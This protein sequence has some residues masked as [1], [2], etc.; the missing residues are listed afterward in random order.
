MKTIVSCLVLVFVLSVVPALSQSMIGAGGSQGAGCSIPSP[1][2]LHKCCS[3]A[4]ES[5]FD[6][7]YADCMNKV[8]ASE[9]GCTGSAVGA[10]SET[11]NLCY[12]GWVPLVRALGIEVPFNVELVQNGGAFP[13]LTFRASKPNDAVLR[14]FRGSFTAGTVSVNGI[15]VADFASPAFRE[16]GFIF[17][18]AHL[19]T[20]TNTITV[21]AQ[22]D[23]RALVQFH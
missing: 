20:G 9:L 3:A 17:V 23:G 6:A 13:L 11:Y 10:Q 7:S 12:L 14:V 8:G 16:T 2:N 15:E 18:E 19:I 22:A 1:Y 5:A 4:G 21:E